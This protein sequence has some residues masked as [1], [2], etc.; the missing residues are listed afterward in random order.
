VTC[1]AWG[2]ESISGRCIPRLVLLDPVTFSKVHV[3]RTS[4]IVIYPVQ[5]PHAASL[6]GCG[7]S[8]RWRTAKAIRNFF[9]RGAAR[10]WPL[11]NLS[12]L[13]S[14]FIPC[15]QRATTTTT[16]I[17]VQR[18]RRTV[19]V[20]ILRSFTLTYLFE[21][22]SAGRRHEIPTVTATSSLT[23]AI[24]IREERGVQRHR[25]R[26]HELP[27]QRRRWPRRA[28]RTGWDGRWC[29]CWCRRCP[30]DPV[31]GR[32]RRGARAAGV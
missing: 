23:P 17:K 26:H 10:V 14:P 8:R 16:T 2:S 3:S 21:S 28:G 9:G 1:G 27:R 19:F 7:L 18:G 30:R 13:D 22:R 29:W 12:S 25:Y 15:S 5:I 20:P 31:G 4:I 6:R 11:I 32:Q 24:V